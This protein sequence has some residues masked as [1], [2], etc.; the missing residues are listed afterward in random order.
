M[1]GSETFI[2]V[3]LRCTE[4]STPRCLATC[5][6]SARNCSSAALRMT[7]ASMISPACTAN[8]DLRTVVVPSAPTCSMRIWVAAGSV[9]DFSE[10]RKSPSVMVAT[11]LLESLL[12]APIECGCLRA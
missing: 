7:A 11:E 4:N 1:I 12:H 9:T 6:C 5:T 2:I 3:A 8:G 10:C